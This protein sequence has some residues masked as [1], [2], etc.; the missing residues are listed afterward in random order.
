MYLVLIVEQAGRLFVF[1]YK[2]VITAGTAPAGAAAVPLM[3]VVLVMLSLSIW[4]REKT[5]S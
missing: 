3:I 2:P 1:N 4:Q 5:A